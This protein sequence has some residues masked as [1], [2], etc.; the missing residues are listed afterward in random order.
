LPFEFT[1]AASVDGVLAL[2]AAHGA[3]AR[4]IA[5]GTSLT[6]GLRSGRVQ[7][8]VVVSIGRLPDLRTIADESGGLAIGAGVTLSELGL[9][10]RV[11]ALAKTLA[12][13]ALAYRSPQI[14]NVATLGGVL[15]SDAR[16]CEPAVALLAL[17]ASAEVR[18]AES[19]RTLL[20]ADFLRPDGSRDLRPTELVSRVLVPIPAGYLGAYYQVARMGS[21]DTPFAS[22][23]VCLKL[24]STGAISMATVAIGAALSPRLLTIAE[25]ALIGRAPATVTPDTVLPACA[26]L[27]VGLDTRAS[28]GYLRRM[29]AVAIARAVA[30][31]VSGQSTGGAL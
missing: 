19:A 18:S 2:L 17:G 4:L 6:Y 29:C 10:L 22:A 24:G 9:S 11:S 3:S 15:C 26:D 5:G 14:R 12:D 13:S 27:P 21:V 16:R 28:A 1:E 20:L 7:P 8:E 31:A 25:T 30:S 23:A